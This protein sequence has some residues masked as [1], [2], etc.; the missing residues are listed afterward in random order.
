MLSRIFSMTQCFYYTNADNLPKYFEL[1]T[2]VVDNQLYSLFCHE[3]FNVTVI[4]LNIKEK[5]ESTQQCPVHFQ[6]FLGKNLLFSTKKTL[7]VF[8]HETVCSIVSFLLYK[9]T[10]YY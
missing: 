10:K 9:L 5:N 6:I 8:N 1:R 3:S 2:T 7:N 4:E